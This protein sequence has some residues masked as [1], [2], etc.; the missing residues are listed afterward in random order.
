MTELEARRRR[1]VDVHFE[2]RVTAVK[3]AAIFVSMVRFA[4]GNLVREPMTNGAKSGS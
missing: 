4:S 2:V 1:G 3:E